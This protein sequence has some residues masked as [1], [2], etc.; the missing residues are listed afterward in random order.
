MDGYV[1]RR[2]LDFK[3]EGQTTNRRPRGKWKKQ[4]EEEIVRI[5]LRR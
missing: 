2:A 5:G 4:V 3:V 1:L